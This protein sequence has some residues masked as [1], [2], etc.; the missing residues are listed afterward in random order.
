MMTSQDPGMLGVYGFRNRARYDY[1]SLSLATSQSVTAPTVWDHLS[2]R[3]MK[4]LVMGVPQ[5][6]PPKPLNGVL[7]CDFTTPDKNV[8]YTYPA[9]IQAGLD[10]PPGESTSLTSPAFA[11]RTSAPCSAKST[12]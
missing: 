1:E 12:P 6:Y 3:G 7:V 8:T 2:R 9:E 5:T 11:R 10:R 4:S